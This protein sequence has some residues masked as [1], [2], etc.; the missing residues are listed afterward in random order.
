MSPND[1]GGCEDFVFIDDPMQTA[2]LN[3]DCCGNN[4]ANFPFETDYVTVDSDDPIISAKRD[5]FVMPTP[6]EY[7]QAMLK[8]EYFE[9]MRL[10]AFPEELSEVVLMAPNPTESKALEDEANWSSSAVNPQGLLV[11]NANL[12]LECFFHFHGLYPKIGRDRVLFTVKKACELSST[13]SEHVGLTFETLREGRMAFLRKTKDTFILTAVDHNVRELARLVGRYINF[14]SEEPQEVEEE[15][16]KDPAVKK[17]WLEWQNILEN[18]GLR[19]TEGQWETSEDNTINSKGTF[20][21]I[22]TAFNPAFDRAFDQNFDQNDGRTRV[23]RSRL[24]AE[25][26]RAADRLDTVMCHLDECGGVRSGGLARDD[27]LLL[28]RAL[29]RATRWTGRIDRSD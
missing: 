13:P 17:L 29:D 24:V 15:W 9:P 19:I 27:R 23:Q 10:S 12:L 3:D 26:V 4:A 7:K 6:D 14:K 21:D 16:Y 5:T 20:A 11:K 28:R 2:S 22:F 25:A 1:N 8:I 18:K